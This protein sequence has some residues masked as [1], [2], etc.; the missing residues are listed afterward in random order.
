MAKFQS[1]LNFFALFLALIAF[2]YSLQS[3][4]RLI[5]PL[6]QQNVPISTS[7][8]KIDSS[9]NSNNEEVTFQPTSENHTNAFQ[10]TTPGNSPGVGH[11]SFPKEDIN[12]ESK[13]VIVQSPSDNISTT[14][15][16]INDFKKTDPGHSPG[17]GHSFNNKIGN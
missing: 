2:N 6:N 11:R 13:K 9:M 10:P 14:E 17:V 16:I 1:T 4:A 3:H 15:D 12:L 8:K 5:K 7:V